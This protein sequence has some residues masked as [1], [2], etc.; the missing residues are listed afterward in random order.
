MTWTATYRKQMCKLGNTSDESEPIWQ[1]SHEHFESQPAMNGSQ[2]LFGKENSPLL[3][4]H[5]DGFVCVPPTS[6]LLGW[7][8]IFQMFPVCQVGKEEQGCISLGQVYG[9]SFANARTEGTNKQCRVSA[10]L[11][12]CRGLARM[13]VAFGS[14]HTWVGF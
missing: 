14:T 11:R 7:S 5:E 8:N 13:W 12:S 9:F 10:G 1:P 4:K 2:F 6:T 3:V